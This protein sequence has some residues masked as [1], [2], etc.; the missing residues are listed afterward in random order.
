MARI[1]FK[2]VTK[3]YAGDMLAV[4]DPKLEI[5]DKEFVVLLGPSG[6]GKSTTLNMI[7]GLEDVTE[8]ELWFDD[9]IVN[10]PQRAPVKMRVARA[11]RIIG[12]AISADEIAQIFTRA[13]SLFH[14][15]FKI[16]RVADARAVR[17]NSAKVG[18]PI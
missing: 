16:C 15:L 1:E 2:S 3:R 11:N 10:V 4:D 6:C 8:G 7:A 13:Y 12:V 14:A 9:Q 5:R 17:T 18:Q